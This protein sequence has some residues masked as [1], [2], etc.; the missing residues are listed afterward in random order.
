MFVVLTIVFYYEKKDRVISNNREMLARDIEELSEFVDNYLKKDRD[1]LNL[2]VS[3]AEYKIN[4][5]ADIEQFDDIRRDFKAID[6]YTNVLIELNIPKWEVDGVELLNNFS[7][8]DE[9]KKITKADFSIYQK[10]EQG[11]VNVSS[12]YI[13]TSGERMLG[14]IILNSSPIT[15][16]IESGNQ[17]SGRF[18]GK[19]AWFTSS[20]NRIEFDGKT[21]GIYFVGIRERLGTALK[22]IFEKRKYFKSGHPFIIAENGDLLVHPLRTNEDLSKTNLYKSIIRKGKS[23]NNFQYEW[24]E[25]GKGKT[26][27]IYYKFHEASQSY[28]CITYPENEMYGAI[29]QTIVIA[30]LA[31]IVFFII[32]QFVIMVAVRS[33][34]GKL[35]S[36]RQIL[37]KLVKGEKVS[38]DFMGGE[39]EYIEISQHAAKISERF[40]VLSTFAQGLANDNFSQTYPKSFVNDEIGEALI[41]INDKLNEAMYNE[42]IRQKEEKLRS[43]ETEGL[44][45]FVNI[46]QRNRDNLDELCYELI[47]SLVEYLNA[48][49]GALFFLNNENPDDVH[50]VQMATYAFDQK[51]IIN[52]KIYPEQGLIG[53]IYNEKETIY[54]SEIPEGYITIT[55]GLGE[56]APKNLLIVPLLINKEVYGAI[57]I[58]SF[59]VLKGFQIE[60]IE[61]I[62]ENI[63]STINNVLVNNKTR[64]LLEQSREQ[65]RLLTEQEEKMR[66]NLLELRNI[67]KETESDVYEMRDVFHLLESYLFMI[68]MD[69]VGLILAVNQRVV[70]FL[71]FEKSGLI[72]K[73]YSDFSS[74]IP[75][76]EYKILINSWNEI[77]AGKKVQIHL[78][79]LSGP[80]QM[81]T[82]LVHMTPIVEKEKVSTIVIVGM[83]IEGKRNE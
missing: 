51:K 59:N 54:L 45:K 60:F 63:A 69:A 41:K 12:T 28:I 61:K 76:D 5:Y 38:A 53:R 20:Y 55:S 22:T 56:G 25:T 68:K 33:F 52:K 35:R 71:S 57:E 32:I 7:M 26:W 77:M 44:S 15:R 27:E 72:G 24:P 66:K 67:Q 48:N 82:I 49:L 14:D 21:Q 37:S 4:H 47:S 9:L 2:S 74:F 13:N 83:G 11:Y 46:L 81:E 19:S 3:I 62:G 39:K 40:N 18:H 80:D 1:L 10:C 30:V 50:F 58:A 17:Y 23:Y 29:Y 16:A 42:H 43:W 70:D 75:V 65:S 8:V 79:V 34:K 78:K 36:L 64:E 73:H 6:P 31:Y